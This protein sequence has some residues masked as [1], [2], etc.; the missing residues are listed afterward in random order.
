MTIFEE[1]IDNIIYAT[2]FVA[3]HL[4]NVL[5]FIDGKW[6]ITDLMGDLKGVIHW[7]DITRKHGDSLLSSQKCLI[8]KLC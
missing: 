6:L 8:I 2:G 3:S 5:Y 7:R 4:L 1:F